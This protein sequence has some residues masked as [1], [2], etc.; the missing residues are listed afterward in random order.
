MQEQKTWKMLLKHL[1]GE[2]S[3]EEK[4]IFSKWLN[5]NEKNKVLFYKVKVL[6]DDE[7]SIDE[8]FKQNTSLTFWGRFTK[9]K[10]KVFILNQA[11]GNLI[12]FIIGM[13]VTAMFSHYVLEKR[14]LKNLFGLTGRKKIAVNEIPEW[15]QSGIAILVGFIALELINHFFQTKKHLIV[16]GYIKRLYTRIKEAF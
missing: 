1:G 10:I 5:K 2:D 16:W 7:N 4:E 15:L 14:G 13:W 8:S 3:N 12:G 9:Q 11:I 6:W